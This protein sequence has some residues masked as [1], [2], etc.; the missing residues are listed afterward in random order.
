MDHHAVLERHR[1]AL[2][3]LEI[4]GALFRRL[5]FKVVQAEGIRRKKPIPP[6][7]PVR[8]MARVLRMIEDAGA[9]VLAADLARFIAPVG[10][11]A[12]DK[13]LVAG[14]FLGLVGVLRR[15]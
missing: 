9:V 4:A 10:L 6:N 11:L 7:V 2:L 8:W 5:G 15:L 1:L 12:P 13:V 3:H 14:L